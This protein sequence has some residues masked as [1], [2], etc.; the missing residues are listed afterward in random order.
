MVGNLIAFAVVVTITVVGAVVLYRRQKRRVADYEARITEST[1]R[2][3]Q[4][5]I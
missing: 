4:L 1:A 3:A 2:H 5:A